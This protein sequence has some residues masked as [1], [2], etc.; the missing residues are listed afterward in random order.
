MPRRVFVFRWS[1]VNPKFVNLEFPEQVA[2]LISEHWTQKT[3]VAGP[4]PTVCLPVPVLTRLLNA[5]FFASLGREEGRPTEFDVVLCSRDDF[6]Q[7][8]FRFSRFKRV[9]DVRVFEQPRSLSPGELIRLA[10]VTDPDETLILIGYSSTDDRLE[11]WGMVGIGKRP[12][13]SHDRLSEL[14]VRV[15]GPGKLRITVHGSV[16]CN[17]R[18][19]KIMTA[20]RGLINRGHIYDFF[21]ETS[22]QFCQDIKTTTKDNESP[23]EIAERDFRAF[24][25]LMV[26]QELMERMQRLDHG[27]CMLIVPEGSSYKDLNEIVTIKYRCIDKTIWDCLRGRWIL[28]NEYYHGPDESKRDE[29]AS[30]RQDVDQ[31]MEES[32]EAL[33]RLTAI[34]GSVIMTRQFEVLGFGAVIH[35]P[36]KAG[37]KLMRCE[38]RSDSVIETTGVEEYGTRHRSAFEFCYR[39]DPSIA[40]VVSQDGGIKIVRRVNENVCFWENTPFG[41]WGE[42]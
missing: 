40:I 9:F 10:P 38:D 13:I 15:F 21:K 12:S 20:K 26:V 17:Y 7:P 39:F 4:K 19:G 27:G 14:R 16:L 42:I 35:L 22:L 3:P 37:Y 2:N 41:L 25:Y 31:G 28:H 23:T 24:G 34:D 11:I 36:Q 5:C 6:P 8:V 30:Q 32:L 33:V 29:I 1:A 18:D